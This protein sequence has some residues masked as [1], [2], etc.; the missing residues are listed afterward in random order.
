MKSQDTMCAWGSGI[1]NSPWSRPNIWNSARYLP[2]WTTCTWQETTQS[3][4]KHPE[5]TIRLGSPTSSAQIR[6]DLL[7]VAIRQLQGHWK[8]HHHSKA[9]PAFCWRKCL[10]FST[11]EIEHS[12]VTPETSGSKFNLPRTSMAQ[13]LTLIWTSSKAK[14]ITSLA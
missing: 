3:Y 8:F 7:P 13:R 9:I 4:P 14:W 11:I 10:S 12:T 6:A 1:I 2:A 5:A